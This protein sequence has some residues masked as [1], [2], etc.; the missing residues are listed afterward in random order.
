[1]DAAGVCAP[2]ASGKRRPVACTGYLQDLITR[3]ARIFFAWAGR[4]ISSMGPI[5][6]TVFGMRSSH[7]CL[8]LY[9]EDIRALFDA[10]PIGTKVQIV[11]Q[12]TVLGVAKG[13]DLRAGL[14]A[15]RG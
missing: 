13:R 15:T 1:V 14:R 10:I 8:R 9:P 3:S 5:S 11:N 12:P 7:G 6:P 4:P 2:R